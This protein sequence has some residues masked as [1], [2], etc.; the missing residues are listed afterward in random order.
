MDWLGNDYFRIRWRAFC[1]AGGEE[2]LSAD[3]SRGKGG[4]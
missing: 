1:P 3:A 2:W 4:K